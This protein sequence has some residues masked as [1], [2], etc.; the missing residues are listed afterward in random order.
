MS[1]EL[2]RNIFDEGVEAGQSR[3]EIIVSMVQ[4]GIT[5]NTAQIRYKEFAQ[6]AGITSTRVGYKADALAHLDELGADVTD[7]EVRNEVRA[8]LVE[9]FGVATS[10]AN[11]YIKAWAEKEEIEL[12]KSSFGSNPE[13]QAKI[14]NWIVQNPDC[15]KGEFAAFMKEE[16]GR[17]SGSIDETYRGIVLARK[18]QDHGVQF[19][20]A[21]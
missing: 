12:P 6:E 17:S 13:D 11:D 7:Q 9:K 5:L 4:Q 8:A 14:F 1:N 3:D 18:L 16:M 21:A 10:T 15:T 19:A 20:E 2:A